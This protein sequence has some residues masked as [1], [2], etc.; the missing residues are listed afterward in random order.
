MTQYKA[1][2]YYLWAIFLVILQRNLVQFNRFLGLTLAIVVLVFLLS[3]VFNSKG[4]FDISGFDG[5]SKFWYILLLFYSISV[6]IR[7]I[8]DEGKFDIHQIAMYIGNPKYIMPYFLPLFAMFPWSRINLKL[9]LKLSSYLTVLFM[10]FFVVDFNKIME[11]N[12]NGLAHFTVGGGSYEVGDFEFYG[13]LTSLIAPFVLFLLK[14]FLTDKQWR[15][16]AINILLASVLY[17]LTARRSSIFGVSLFIV[18]SYFIVFKKTAKSKFLLLLVLSLLG[19]GL[20]NSGL[21]DF[22]L[23]KVDNDSRSGV[24]MEFMLYMGDNIQYW[25]FGKGAMGTYYDSSPIFFDIDGMRQE[26]ETGYLHLILKGGIIYLALYIIVLIRAFYYGWF[27]SNNDFVKAFAAFALIAVLELIPYGI[28]SFDFKYFA[29]WLG[30]GFCFNKTIR[31][32]TNEEIKVLLS[33]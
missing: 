3:G 13:A 14:S 24:E 20:Y 28:P 17:L 1:F 4:S 23:S 15:Y 6:A 8:V 5:G 25:I 27:K 16:S 11:L 26:I 30:V 29:L 33:N 19:F 22:L 10:I 31:V 7:G 2:N 9:L 12:R 32:K 18:A 21:L